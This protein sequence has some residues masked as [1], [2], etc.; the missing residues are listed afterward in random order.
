MKKER[1]HI[2]EGMFILSATL[3]E[4][5]RKKALE[6]IT[7][8]IKERGGEIHK[9]HDMGKTRLSYEINKK[10]EGVYFLIY[11]SLASIKMDELWKEYHLHE[12]L[13]RFMTMRTEEVKESLEFKPL[14]MS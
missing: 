14:V 4:D 7:N 1:M 2:Y 11:F 8:P 12:D 13:I 9:I 3:S 6:K 10:R 5:A